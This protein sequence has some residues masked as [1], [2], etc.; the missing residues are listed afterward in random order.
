MKRILLVLAFC[1]FIVQLNAQT[2][3]SVSM[4]PGTSVDVYYNLETGNKDTVR[5]NNWHIAFAVRKAQPPLKTMQAATILVNDGRSVDLYKSNTAFADWK[6][7]D[8]TGW[9]AWPQSFNSDSS[10]DIGAFNQARNQSNPFDYG[11]GQYD[12]TSRDVVGNNIWLV[13]ITTS[14]NPSAPKTLKK[15]A[16]HKIAYDTMWIFTFSNV[17]GTDSTTLTIKKSD[18]NNKLFAYVNLVSKT[19]IDREPALNTWDIVFTRYKSLVTLFGQTLMYPVMGVLHHPNAVTAQYSMPNARAFVPDTTLKF[20]S[21]VA[22]IGWDWKLITTTPGAWPVKDS[23]SY[24]IKTGANK[25]Y[26]IYF[27]DY[28]ADQTKQLIKFNK[29]FFSQLTGNSELAK[30]IETLKI[31]P[32]PASAIVNI[33]TVFTK[34]VAAVNVQLIDMTG[35]TVSSETFINRSGDFN[36]AVSTAQLK[37]G[38]YFVSIEAD[39]VKASKKLVI[40]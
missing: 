27:T 4:L 11:W 2:A 26:R 3:D 28:Y 1:A 7:F 10:W 14:P 31:Y 5:N 37:P 29:T 20:T 6:N 34:P 17:D 18:F 16:I 35:R 39:G 9:K 12:M 40:N 30:S 36:V 24:F 23:L 8:T 38:I 25:Y 19:V 22:E 32:N 21:K 33:E 15:L 13:A